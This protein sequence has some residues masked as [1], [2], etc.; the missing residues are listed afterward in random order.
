MPGQSVSKNAGK[1][2]SVRRVFLVFL[3][4]VVF[5]FALAACAPAPPPAL[6]THDA[7]VWQRRWTPALSDA[8]RQAKEIR[9]WR[10]LAAQND[11]SGHLHPVAVDRAALAATGKA[12]VLVI[13]IDGQ[14]AH[15][16][17]AT[18]LADT[19][20]LVAAWK[21]PAS[22]ATPTAPTTTASS[23]VPLAG[24][25]IDHDCATARLP[26]YAN[27][28]AALHRQL[29]QL[30]PALPLSITALPTWLESNDL[31]KALAHVDEAVLQVHA[32][33]HPREGLFD[34]ARAQDWAHAFA[35]RT[36]KPW[37]IALP[38]YGS[39]VRWEKDGD[40]EGS[41]KNVSKIVSIAS[42]ADSLTSG[43]AF[44]EEAVELSASPQTVATFLNTLETSRPRHLA[45]IVWFR[46]PT[47]DDRR[48]W[49]LSTWRAVLRGQPLTPQLR[50]RL[51]AAE[52]TKVPEATNSSSS[53]RS[54][55]A[56]PETVPPIAAAPPA[57]TYHILLE[58]TG[59]IDAPL[60]ARI[61][62]AAGC[63][64]ADAVNGY[65]L[66]RAAQTFSLLRTDAAIL[67]A[68]RQRVIGW[69]RCPPNID[70]R[71]AVR[72]AD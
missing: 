24:I 4:F 9:V 28:L 15:W 32:V 57:T 34:P 17:E 5:A 21:I 48:A 12:A 30:D 53:S 41:G 26:A 61:D 33:S 60:P 66:E 64:F 36:E 11:A 3:V 62:I 71:D 8:L 23:T 59:E 72:I 22:P 63:S 14:L 20:A 65:T 68:Q 69:L 27:F 42:E 55:T 46:L 37:R 7:Y 56:L 16:D 35:R 31:E 44:D 45:G 54:G 70:V 52:M 13:R 49:S 39:R 38:T 50:V 47:A 1:F 51:A 2:F 6:L 67:R 18:L 29:D 58:N 10:V 25:E 40:G 19:L 43:G